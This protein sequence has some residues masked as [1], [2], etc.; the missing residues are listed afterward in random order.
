MNLHIFVSIYVH[1]DVTW[2][3]F[4]LEECSCP[5]GTTKASFT[6]TKMRA[7]LIAQVHSSS[8]ILEIPLNNPNT[9]E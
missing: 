4:C 2:I 9:M 3:D 6:L 5:L 8:G 7:E 1:Q